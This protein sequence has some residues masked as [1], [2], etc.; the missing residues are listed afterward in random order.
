[1]WY[2]LWP[3]MARATNYKVKLAATEKCILPAD[4]RIKC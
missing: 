4:H 3:Y 1:M 2:M